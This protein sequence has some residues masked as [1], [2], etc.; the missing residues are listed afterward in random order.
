MAFDGLRVLSLESRRAVEIERLIRNQGGVAFVAPSVREVPLEQNSAALDFGGRLF[1]GG[2]DMVILLTG[3]GARLL[4]QVMETRWPAGS[5][6][7]ALKKVTVV[8]R[9]PKPA[10]VMREWGVPIAITAPEPNTWREILAST[11]GRPER[12][13]AVQEYGRA[14]EELVQGLEARGAEVTQVP[15][16]Q[17]ELPEDIE[18]LR[19]AARRLA[20]GEID[21]VLFT[22]SIQVENLFRVAGEIGLAEAAR[23]GMNRA[24]IASIGPTTSETLRAMNLP[25]DFEPSHPK[26]GFLLNEAAA[27]ARA[28]LERKKG[29]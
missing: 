16:Y 19:E 8:V 7:E 17:W 5:L 15:V 4:N 11:E 28:I 14:S 18:P 29:G 13:I 2:F 22:A 21:V 12:R 26:M 9:G 20:R 3:V 6:A 25:V 24:V 1:T 10:A 27:E 23:K